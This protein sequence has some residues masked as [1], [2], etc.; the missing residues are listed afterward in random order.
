VKEPMLS[1]NAISKADAITATQLT[2]KV[3]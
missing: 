3:W 1:R 2:S